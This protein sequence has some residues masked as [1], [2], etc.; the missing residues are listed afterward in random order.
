M[1]EDCLPAEWPQ[2][3]Y[4]MSAFPMKDGWLS[5]HHFAQKSKGQSENPALFAELRQ[6]LHHDS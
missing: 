4:K 2:S 3:S 6:S 5:K 1:P